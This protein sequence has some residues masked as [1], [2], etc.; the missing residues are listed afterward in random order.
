MNKIFVAN[1]KMNKTNSE[2]L[3]YINTF[4]TLLPKNINNEICL[5]LP[6]T[7]LVLGKFLDNRIKIGAQNM[8]EQDCGSFTGEVSADMLIELG[9]K[10]VIIGHS[11]RR[12]YY[13]ETNER[14]NKKIKN[15]L[16]H[17]LKIIL[18]IGETKS[19]KKQ[20][21][22][23]EILKSQLEEALYDIYENELA[24]IIIA[25]EPVWAIGT[26]DVAKI[27]DIEKSIFN[28]KNILSKH[29][30]L[31]AANEQKIIYGGSLT[32]LTSKNI[33]K[34]ENVS[35]AL[36]GGASLNPNE[37]IKIICN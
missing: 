19:Q 27:E 21:R 35:G 37:F 33:L 11:E 23:N 18:C 6:F 8:H 10:Y 12:K 36:I 9:V 26:G 29:Y 15:A 3:D 17:G 31:K 5:C 2:V 16:R 30:S 13:N 34:S 1:F 28:I 32:S 7:S 22:T 24:N 14:I 4:N 25:Y 20:H